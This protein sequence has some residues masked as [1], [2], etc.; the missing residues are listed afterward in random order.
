MEDDNH[1]RLGTIMNIG[2]KSDYESPFKIE[3]MNS[4]EHI[5]LRHMF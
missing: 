5:L 3:D 1:Y 2:K 4:L